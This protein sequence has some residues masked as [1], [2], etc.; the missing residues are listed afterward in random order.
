MTGG[1]SISN[2]SNNASG[3]LIDGTARVEIYGHSECPI[4]CA[5]DPTATPCLRGYNAWICSRCGL[6]WIDPQPSE[7][8]LIKVY[9]MAGLFGL[10]KHTNLENYLGNEVRL[11]REAF[12]RLREMSRLAPVTYV[13]DVGCAMGFF[14]DEAR[15][16]TAQVQGLEFSQ[17][18]AR[19][20]QE[21]FNIP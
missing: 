8:E 6:L 16:Y 18:A 20:A 3:V 1:D 17:D 7:A 21:R 11:R 14:L 15:K 13:L 5:P 2:V 10:F 9:S 4:C 19:V 12:S